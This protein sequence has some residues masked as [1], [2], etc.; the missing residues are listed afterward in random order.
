MNLFLNSGDMV[1]LHNLDS[2][3]NFIDEQLGSDVMIVFRNMINDQIGEIKNLQVDYD[4]QCEST[5]NLDSARQQ[6]MEELENTIDYIGECERI[7]R[8][9][10]INQLKE[11]YDI[12]D[13]VEY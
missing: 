3:E 13:A 2:F 12:L 6:A 8:S 4:I 7:N 10:I 1:T 11:I 9:K 5:K